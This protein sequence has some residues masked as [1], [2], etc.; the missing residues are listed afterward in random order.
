MDIKQDEQQLRQTV[1]RIDTNL[2]PKLAIASQTH[3]VLLR[4]FLDDIPPEAEPILP[5][6]TE[7]EARCGIFRHFKSECDQMKSPPRWDLNATALAIIMV[8]PIS[9][10]RMVLNN[11]AGLSDVAVCFGGVFHV[12]CKEAVAGVRAYLSNDEGHNSPRRSILVYQGSGTPTPAKRR[13]VM[14]SNPY[15]GLR[16]SGFALDTL[17][18]ETAHRLVS[19]PYRPN[20]K[21]T[22]NIVTLQHRNCYGYTCAITGLPDPE[23]ANIFPTTV[24]PKGNLAGLNGMLHEFWGE[25]AFRAWEKLIRDDRVLESPKN[26][27]YLNRQLRFW[28][29]KARFALKPLRESE[30]EVVVQWHWLKR[31]CL[32]PKQRLATDDFLAEAGL[33]DQKWGRGLAHRSSGVAIETGQVFS[34]RADNPLFLPSFELLRLRWDLLRVATISG[35]SEASDADYARY[36]DDELEMSPGEAEACL[37]MP[38]VAEESDS[39]DEYSY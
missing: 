35:A 37:D 31:A 26:V 12:L 6:I 3:R 32:K 1:P 17:N 38:V 19:S 25:G 9:Q 15:F 5:Y 24:G 30:K 4:D 34:I 27:V 13:H 39:E 28:W 11:I 16:H 10:L 14:M 33:V 20:Q 21:H 29:D 7:L 8:A 22:A 18:A 2:L 23:A 36:E